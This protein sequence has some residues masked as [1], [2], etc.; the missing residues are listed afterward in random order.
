MTNLSGA[1]L[2]GADLSN[3]KLSAAC[4]DEKTELPPGYTLP[5]CPIGRRR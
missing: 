4:G 2:G 1:R 5:D 3:A